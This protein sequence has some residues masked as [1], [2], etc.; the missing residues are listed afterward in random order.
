MRLLWLGGGILLGLWL[1]KSRSQ[2]PQAE[3]VAELPDNPD[4]SFA[5]HVQGEMD[6]ERQ[7]V[8]EA[9]WNRWRKDNITTCRIRCGIIKWIDTKCGRTEKSLVFDG[10]MHSCL[11][12]FSIDSLY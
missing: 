8:N 7:R 4:K 5:R 6:L 10:I 12:V 1:A 9:Y 11:Q 3:P 2:E